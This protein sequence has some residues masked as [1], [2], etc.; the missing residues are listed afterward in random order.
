MFSPRAEI[1]CI[2]CNKFEETTFVPLPV[3]IVFFGPN[4]FGFPR[5]LI[6]N[7]NLSTINGLKMI[8]PKQVGQNPS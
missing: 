3:K 8:F 2:R 1:G 4:F 7:M 6:D 5:Q